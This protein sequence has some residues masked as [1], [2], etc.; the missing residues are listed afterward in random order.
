M[1]KTLVATILG[2]ATAASVHAQG[3]IVM[4]TYA[5]AVA[6]YP[7]ITYGT[8][9]VPIPSS[10]GYTVGFYYSTV[11]ATFN[12]PS[13]TGVP[14]G[15]FVLATGVGST[16]PLGAIP[17]SA[18]LFTSSTD[19][20]IPGNFGVPV[21]LVVVAYNGANYVTSTLRGHSTVFTVTANNSFGGGTPLGAAMQAFNIPIPEPSTFA[22]AGL[23]L[24]GLLIF[25][26]RK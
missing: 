13:G 21:Y 11:A 26:R 19:F 4:D 7:L 12:D 17:A 23:G 2:I 9:G 24:A 1:K 20:V 18:G 6:P 15:T 5:S 25:R 14:G 3:R 22:L 16:A 10:S 8:S